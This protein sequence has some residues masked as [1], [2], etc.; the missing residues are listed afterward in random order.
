MKRNVRD[1][2]NILTATILCC[3]FS[4]ASQDYDWRGEIKSGK[5]PELK[6]HYQAELVVDEMIN[7]QAWIGQTGLNVAFGS[8]D[9]L[10]FRREKP[11]VDPNASVYQATVWKGE[12]VNIQI[13]VWSSDTLEQVRAVW[14]N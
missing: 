4:V 7:E 5:L 12:R 13:L 11:D 1:Y 9:Q 2:R 10:Y 14:A 3:A 6:P 8:T